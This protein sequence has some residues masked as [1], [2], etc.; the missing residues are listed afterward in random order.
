MDA[1]GSLREAFIHHSED[2][3]IRIKMA[4]C[5]LKLGEEDLALKFLEEALSMDGSLE[6]EFGYF[7]PEGSRNNKVERIIQQYK[8]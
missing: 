2:A 6:S 1:L 4:V 7:Y 3:G 5:H 8:K